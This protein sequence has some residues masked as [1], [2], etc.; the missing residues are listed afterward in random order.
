MSPRGSSPEDRPLVQSNYLLKQDREAFDKL[1]SE[2]P[3]DIKDENDELA[4]LDQMFS[5]PQRRPTDIRSHFNRLLTQ[6]RNQ[7]QKDLKKKREEF[8]KIERKDRDVFVK[9]LAQERESFKQKKANKE[10]T[11]QFYDE[12]DLKRKDFFS[13]QKEK[14]EIFEAQ[15]RDDRKNYADYSKAIQ[16]DFNSRLKVFTDQQKAINKK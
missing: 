4:L 16:L 1:R 15:V 7:F 2:I 14:R 3:T 5:N 11:K 6:K 12:L 8:V 13:E 9:Q 10:K